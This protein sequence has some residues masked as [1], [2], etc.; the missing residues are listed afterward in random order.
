MRP[1]VF[2]SSGLSPGFFP[3]QGPTHVSLVFLCWRPRRSRSPIPSVAPSWWSPCPLLR[4]AL[5]PLSCYVLSVPSAFS[6]HR[7]CLSIPFTLSPLSRRVFAVGNVICVGSRRSPGDSR[8]LHL[9]RL[10]PDL[11]S[12]RGLDVRHS[13]LRSVVNTFS[14]VAFR[15]YSWR[16]F[17]QFN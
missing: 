2:E 5:L 3:F 1:R 4:R 6:L 10:K 11:V 8:W 12:L 14:C 9:Y 15:M 13:G 16:S 7:S 17:H